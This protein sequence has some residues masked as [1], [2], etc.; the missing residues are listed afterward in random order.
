ML[1]RK[2]FL[3]L[4]NAQ[5]VYDDGVAGGSKHPP[6]GRAGD[7]DTTATRK[8]RAEQ[9]EKVQKSERRIRVVLESR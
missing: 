2:E 8:H 6:G 1:I 4:H 5:P 3:I 7:N 9:R